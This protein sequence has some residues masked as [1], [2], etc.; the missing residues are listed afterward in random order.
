M[1][2]IQPK[3]RLEADCWVKT[4]RTKRELFDWVQT[5]PECNTVEGARLLDIVRSDATTSRASITA[6]LGFWMR[7][8]PSGLM[9]GVMESAISTHASMLPYMVGKMHLLVGS[10]AI[11]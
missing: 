9:L 3:Q 5:R 4:C 6:P 10:L 11:E 8:I 2:N 1:G 7:H